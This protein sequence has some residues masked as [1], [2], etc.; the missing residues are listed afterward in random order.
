MG[1]L[2]CASNQNDVLADFMKSGV[3][4]ANR[5]FYT[6]MSPS[7]DILISSNLERLLY[8]LCGKDDLQVA[9]MMQELKENRRYSISQEMKAQLDADFWGGTV[10]DEICRGIIKKTLDEIG[11]LI[12]P[13]TSVAFG[14]YD[15]YKTETGDHTPAV[16][17]STASPFKFAGSV[18]GALGA[19]RPA[20]EFAAVKALSQGTGAPIPK[21]IAALEKAKI[22]FTKVLLPEE[23][24]REIELFASQK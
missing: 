13:H 8:E 21:N 23:M 16:I 12:D 17:L 2:I 7:M 14:V 9:A 10:G 20:D 24:P 1:K 11:Y 22:R 15:Q 3:Y 6:T 5:N 4:D 18:L 19:E